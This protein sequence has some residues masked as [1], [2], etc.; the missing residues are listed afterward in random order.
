MLLETERAHFDE[1]RDEYVRYYDGQWIL[2]HGADFLGAY[3][4]EEQAYE[5]ALAKVGSQPVLIQHVSR[6][7]ERVVA[8]PS[9]L[10]GLTSG[11]S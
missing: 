10:A 4:T 11:R 3:S 7:G 5:A 1:H 6:H 8:I 2:V 9:L